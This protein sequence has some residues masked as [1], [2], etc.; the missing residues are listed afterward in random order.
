LALIRN[1]PQPVAETPD[2]P[3]FFVGPAIW[4]E[5]LPPPAGPDSAPRAPVFAPRWKSASVTCK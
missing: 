4:C 2:F 5:V 1:Q 3:G